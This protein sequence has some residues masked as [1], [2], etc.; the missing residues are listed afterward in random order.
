MLRPESGDCDRAVDDD[1]MGTRGRAWGQLDPGWN[2]T[3]GR[4]SQFLLVFHMKRTPKTTMGPAGALG[5]GATRDLA[6]LGNRGP[7]QF[8][9]RTLQLHTD[10]TGILT[11]ADWST[12]GA[13]HNRRCRSGHAATGRSPSGNSAIKFT[14]VFYKIL[15]KG[16]ANDRS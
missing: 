8:Q 16:W 11:A 15:R 2:L 3:I 4:R 5:S 13:D 10:D 9:G 12:D 1:G 6:L 14:R 7:A